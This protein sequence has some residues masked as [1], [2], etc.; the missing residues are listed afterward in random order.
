MVYGGMGAAANGSL[1][2]AGF[3]HLSVRDNSQLAARYMPG[4]SNILTEDSV[5]DPV[6]HKG[7]SLGV[8]VAA[9]IFDKFDAD[10]NG[11]LPNDSL[12]S[13]AEAVW[14]ALHYDGPKLTEKQKQDLKASKKTNIDDPGAEFVTFGE[15]LL[16][17]EDSLERLTG[18]PVSEVSRPISSSGLPSAYS[19]TPQY[20]EQAAA[21]ARLETIEKASNMY[22]RSSLPSSAMYAPPPQAPLPQNVAAGYGVESRR[23]MQTGSESLSETQMR[24]YQAGGTSIPAN[25]QTTDL[26]LQMSNV[27]GQAGVKEALQ[28]HGGERKQEEAKAT[29]EAPRHVPEARPEPVKSTESPAVI[30]ADVMA[31][32]PYGA[33]TSQIYACDHGCG[34]CGSFSEV[35]IHEEKCL[36]RI[37]PKPTK[38][39]SMNVMPNKRM[40][41]LDPLL[42]A[43]DK[44]EEWN[45]DA[46]SS[47]K[48]SPALR[49]TSS[50]TEEPVRPSPPKARMSSG[51]SDTSLGYDTSH[52]YDWSVEEVSIPVSQRIQAFNK[53][54]MSPKFMGKSV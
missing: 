2:N 51:G 30:P 35:A 29:V 10:K 34:F 18:P 13:C 54:E 6:K 42:E 52:D 24:S 11:I 50:K 43:D 27:N 21:L 33:E 1:L 3:S 32:S 23:S 17:Y 41:T 15:F 9:E 36:N 5:P 19:T 39:I 25:Y 40:S 4:A 16:W 12:L 20:L 37:P 46:E 49:A 53:G 14:D 31:E 48:I 38:R 7:T 8:E 22:N 26:G 28:S 47:P 45:E 44:E